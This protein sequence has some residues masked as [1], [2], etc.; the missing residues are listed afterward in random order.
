MS[1]SQP[2]RSAVRLD[3]EEKKK[4]L[5]H[6]EALVAPS[7]RSFSKPRLPKTKDASTAKAMAMLNALLKHKKQGEK[8]DAD[9]GRRGKTS[10]LNGRLDLRQLI[11]PDILERYETG[12][13]KKIRVAD[14]G[15]GTS[16]PKVETEQDATGVVEG[17]TVARS[18][19]ETSTLA[20]EGES[21]EEAGPSTCDTMSEE[22]GKSD[23]QDSF[24]NGALSQETPSFG[25][26]GSAPNDVEE[27]CEMSTPPSVLAA[28]QPL[29]V[30]NNLGTGTVGKKRV[31]GCERGCEIEA[32]RQKWQK[33][34]ISLTHFFVTSGCSHCATVERQRDAANLLLEIREFVERYKQQQEML[35]AVFSIFQ[36]TSGTPVRSDHLLPFIAP[37]AMTY[38]LYY[39]TSLLD[40]SMAGASR[41]LCPF[42]DDDVQ[43]I[44]EGFDPEGS[45]LVW[46]NLPHVPVAV[47]AVGGRLH[48]L[49]LSLDGGG[50]LACHHPQG[51]LN[52]LLDH[53]QVVLRARKQAFQPHG[54]VVEA[55]GDVLADSGARVD[56]RVK[57]KWV[58]ASE[59]QGV[60][61][62]GLEGPP[63]QPGNADAVPQQSRALE[64]AV[65]RLHLTRLRIDQHAAP[66]QPGGSRL[67]YPQVSPT[68]VR[69]GIPMA[70][71]EV[72]GCLLAVDAAVVA[73]KAFLHHR[74]KCARLLLRSRQVQV[75][76]H[77]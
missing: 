11:P 5:N 13:G 74:Q 7:E 38:Y 31:R 18:T 22:E 50:V 62:L 68:F 54:A 26:D 66:P 10:G 70:K 51:A 27:G 45:D 3:A 4:E 6:A 64:A 44:Q 55:Q 75:I 35:E 36:A 42:L 19:L 57:Q 76:V 34:F 61:K 1:S 56:D 12:K 30:G 23:S 41:R 59:H 39:M 32:G 77:E 60:A 33:C 25:S 28:P 15:Q 48:L 67:I 2:T 8:R 24:L 46:R 47:P 72:A 43:D 16:S 52:G 73:G 17:T 69:A 49:L 63:R 29:S 71:A 14:S 53:R 58:G 65:V 37:N 21:S 40:L 9:K 20:R